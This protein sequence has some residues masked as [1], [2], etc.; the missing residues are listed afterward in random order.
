MPIITKASARAAGLT[1]YFTGKPCKRGHVCERTVA[2]GHCVECH[3]MADSKYY[4]TNT[5]KIRTK[6]SVRKKRERIQNRE[7]VLARE[8]A[9]REKNRDSIR[10]YTA[11]WQKANRDKVREYT[12]SWYAANSERH[13]EFTK[14]WKKAN[15]SASAT[16][17]RNRRALRVAAEGTHTKDD[18]KR[19]FDGQRGKCAYCGVSIKKRFHVD[20]IVALINGGSNWAKNL[21]LL[22]QPCNQKKAK[23]DP[24]EF[25]QRCGKLL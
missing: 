10:A 16:Y 7:R 3:R 17:T 6:D 9:W 2:G 23:S 5:T 21:Q 11:C 24:I 4:E 1:R 15:P 25:A 20:H 8:A 19:I 18:I 13:A 22:C 14:A 12:R